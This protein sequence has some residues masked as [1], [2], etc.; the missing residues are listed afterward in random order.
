LRKKIQSVQRLD[1]VGELDKL[2]IF[3]PNLSDSK[4]KTPE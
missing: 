1:K 4:H 3:A 2:T